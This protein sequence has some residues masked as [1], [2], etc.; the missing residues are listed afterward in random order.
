ML[1]RPFGVQIG[2]EYV[3]APSA[4]TANW[5][6]AVPGLTPSCESVG[7]MVSGGTENRV[8][9]VGGAGGL[10]LHRQQPQLAANARNVM[11]SQETFRLASGVF[12]MVTPAAIVSPKR[13]FPGGRESSYDRDSCNKN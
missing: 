12:F 8:S 10:V 11:S 13:V 7:T 4:L 6:A 3:A 1:R 5:S 9:G 2:Y